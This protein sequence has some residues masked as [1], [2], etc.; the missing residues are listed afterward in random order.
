MKSRLSM[1]QSMTTTRIETVPVI[2]IGPFLAGNAAGK[3]AVV[4]Q[5]KQACEEIGFITVVGH[6]VPNNLLDDMQRVSYD[7]FNQPQDEKRKVFKQ[8]SSAPRGYSGLSSASLARSLG[9]EAPPDL[10]EGYSVG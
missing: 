6:G 4:S 10:Q 7:F 3:A 1:E 2:D 9:K 5:V 8:S